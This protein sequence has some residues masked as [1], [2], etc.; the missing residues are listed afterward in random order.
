[1]KKLNRMK[2]H[3]LNEELY[4]LDELV[5]RDGKVD[6]KDLK[7]LIERTM[8]VLKDIVDTYDYSKRDTH[9][10]ETTINIMGKMMSI[11]NMEYLK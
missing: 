7:G 1:M 10:V 4:D 2:T 3:P 5:Q 8:A 11:N 9:L 6:I